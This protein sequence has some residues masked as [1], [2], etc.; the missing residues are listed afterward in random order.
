MCFNKDLRDALLYKWKNN[1]G[2]VIRVR[3]VAIQVEDP[4]EGFASPPPS[5]FPGSPTG[6]FY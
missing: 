5:S 4:N 6:G 2:A 1:S 3:A